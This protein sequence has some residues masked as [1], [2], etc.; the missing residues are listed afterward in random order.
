MEVLAAISHYFTD[1]HNVAEG[2]GAAV[3]AALMQYRP[4]G[5]LGKGQTAG[6]VLTGGNIDEKSS[7]RALLLEAAEHEKAEQES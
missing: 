6:V 3:L 4:Q 1:T 7:R 2:A 5:L